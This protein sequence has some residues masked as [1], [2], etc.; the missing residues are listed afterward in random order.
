MTIK[1]ERS[2]QRGTNRVFT[3]PY[4]EEIGLKG[5]VGISYVDLQP[6]WILSRF[7][8]FEKKAFSKQT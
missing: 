1:F 3:G 4:P 2:L 5:K 6:C 8:F 7:S